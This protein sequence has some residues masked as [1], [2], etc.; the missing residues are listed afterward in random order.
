[1]DR[2]DALTVMR[3][4]GVSFEH[5]NEIHSHKALKMLSPRTFC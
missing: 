4:L 5:Y 1:M 3:Q 2:P